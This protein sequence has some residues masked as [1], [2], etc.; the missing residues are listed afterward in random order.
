MTQHDIENKEHK[1][2]KDAY[3]QVLQ[4]HENTVSDENERQKY[5]T[6][7]R[8]A[9]VLVHNAG[10]LQALSF[11]L[12]KPKNYGYLKLAAQILEWDEIAANPTKGNLNSAYNNLL[13]LNEYELMVCTK[14]VMSYI[15]WLK[16]FSEAMLRKAK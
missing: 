16:R 2:A 12:S 5:L 10:L 14:K 7:I 6:T 8:S 9:G 13:Q 11:Y 4:I 15:A 3:N 1:F